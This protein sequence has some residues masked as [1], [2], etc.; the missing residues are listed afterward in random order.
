M[1]VSRRWPLLPLVLAWPMAWATPAFPQEWAEPVP[2]VPATGEPAEAA[3]VVAEPARATPTEDAP[4]VFKLTGAARA[5]ASRTS[6]FG[7]DPNGTRSNDGV[8]GGSRITVQAEFDTGRRLG[9]WSLQATFAADALSGTFAGG[10]TIDGD[11]LPGNR[12]DP[13]LATQAWAGLSL[14]DL[15]TVRAG[16][17]TSHWGLG[18]VA[19]DGGHALDSR[20]DDWFVLPTTG[21]RVARAQLVLQPFGRT[22][23]TARG[24]FLAFSMDQ[25]I[26]DGTAVYAQGD[27]AVQEVAAVKWHFARERWAGIYFV[28]RDQ[29]FHS[30]SGPFLRVNVVD[31][32]FDLDW[33]KAGT[34]LRLQGE[35]ALILGRTDLAP[36]PEHAEHDVRQSAAVAKARYDMGE[37]GLR[38]ELDGGWFSGDN[39]L[40][41]IALTG[42]KANPNYQQGIL[43]F[44]QV[45]GWQ[46]G[47][48][49]VTASNPQLSGYPSA[50]LDRLASGGSVTSAITAFPKVGWK[51]ASFLEIYGG[52]LFAFAPTAPIDAFSTHAVGGGTAR[53]YLGKVPTGSLLGTELDFGAVATLTPADWP[54]GLALRGEYAVLLP[55][56][57]EAGQDGDSPIHGGR[58]SL[59]LLP[60]L[61]P[62]KDRP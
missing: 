10:P 27:N 62:A 61:S 25:V 34:G 3:Q 26:E 49:R 15:G 60:K 56:G 51:A 54:V 45:L 17:M 35:A 28:H 46:T 22:D 14:R 41:D 18:L 8:Q 29:T 37:M 33:R 6:S 53:N 19:N 47:R 38:F 7:V 40:D 30:T 36:T 48:A 24:L 55:G 9:D 39:N 20:R 16:L 50:D 44:S 52:A 21:D 32:A 2:V 5:T 57:V 31:G 1:F 42:F 58:I 23:S 59:A 43:L 12:W 4:G 13:V 11:K